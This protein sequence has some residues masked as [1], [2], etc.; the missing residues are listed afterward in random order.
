MWLNADNAA[1]P[2]SAAA[3][4]HIHLAWLFCSP[5]VGRNADTAAGPV[6]AADVAHIHLAWLFFSP[7]VGQ[8]ADIAADPLLAAAVAHIYLADYS[9]LQ[10]WD[11]MHI[12]QLV[13]CQQQLLLIFI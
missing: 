3:V 11:G 9:S 12:L 13:L 1:G 10:L 4:A 5:A 8:N 2:V 6:S 7:A